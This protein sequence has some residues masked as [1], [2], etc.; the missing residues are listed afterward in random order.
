MTDTPF[1]SVVSVAY[2]DAWA[3]M[4]TARSVFGQSFEDFEYIVVDGGSS[5]HTQELVAF[6]EAAGLVTCALSE[7]DTGVYNAMNKGLGLARGEVVLFLNA[8]DIFADDGV[9]ARVHRQFRDDPALDGVLGW[10][11]LKG[12]YWTSWTES[13]AVKMAS[14]GFC[15][16]ALYVRRAR[17]A[18]H[19]FD[20]RR[21]KTDSDTLQLGRLYADGADIAI[22]PEVL[23][24]RGGEPGISAD[25]ERTRVSIVA[26][27]TEDYP[28]LDADDAEAVLAFRRR[29]ED[30]DRIA[31]LMAR[32]DGAGDARLARHLACM[33][34]DTL[35]QRPSA[36]LA[37]DRA[38]ALMAQAADLLMDGDE[39]GRGAEDVARLVHVQ[40]RRADLLDQART[41]RQELTAATAK[42]ETEEARRIETAQAAYDLGPAGQP[43][44][45]VVSL[46]TFPARL[47]TVHLAI[48]SLLEQ[49]R[50]PAAIHLWLGRDEIPSHNWLPGKLRELEREG[51]EVH[52]ADRTFHQYDKILHNA[53]LNADA[54]FVIVDD[55]VIYPP[56][57][58][59]HLWSGH[60]AH[61][62]AVIANRCHGMVID[63]AGAFAPYRDW[64]REVRR[65]EP[66]LSLLPTGAGGVLYPPGCL[67][68]PRMTDIA[69]LLAH[70]PYADDI[71]LKFCA[72]AQGRP[73]FATA[74]SRGSDWYHRYTPTMR[75]GTLMDI[76]VS[77][78]LNDLQIARAAAWLDGQRPGWRAALQA[79]RFD[80]GDSA[81]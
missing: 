62:E 2:N 1:F 61:P 59:D 46:T 47:G 66:A 70:A 64:P 56:L 23:A 25:L 81:A 5:D 65:P 55:D 77:R 48:R 32:A 52:F 36:Q 15:H 71:W 3:L 18:A 29:C 69:A 16:Q 40:N 14:L 41:A 54:A 42:F 19:P 11:E 27:L 37:E 68:D 53:A 6:W 26:T 38:A 33:V 74:L 39:T 7:P 30:P 20:E 43:S 21:F 34:L 75:A 79:E 44:E 60:Q 31:A 35:F 24:I 45:M 12:Q 50:R 76:N 72:L 63:G 8:S 51:L 57:A 49:T 28:G 13:E 58:L 80:A 10:G 67:T 22:L 4:K 73:T 9:L 17:L 78:G